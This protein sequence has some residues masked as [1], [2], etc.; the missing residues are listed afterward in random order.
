MLEVPL[1]TQMWLVL[2]IKKHRTLKFVIQRPKQMVFSQCVVIYVEL[3][4]RRASRRIK[5]GGETTLKALNQVNIF[6]SEIHSVAINIFLVCSILKCNNNVDTSPLT[7][8]F[9]SCLSSGRR[10]FVWKLKSGFTSSLDIT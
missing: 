10:M 3:G 2:N 4:R 6:C 8:Q 5:K 9:T 1:K 7:E